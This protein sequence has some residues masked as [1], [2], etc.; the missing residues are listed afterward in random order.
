M[1]KLFL[2]AIAT[3]LFAIS[4]FLLQISCKKDVTAQTNGFT[5][6]PATTSTLG[7]VIVDGTTIKVDAAGKISVVPPSSSNEGAI[8]L[9]NKRTSDDAPDELWRANLDGSG[10]QKINVA[11]PAGIALNLSDGGAMKL[12]PDNQK[13]IF[14]A[15]NTSTNQ[16]YIYSCNI[17]GTG[18]AKLVDGPL[19]GG[20]ELG[21]VN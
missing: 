13:V 8:I 14:L 20:L 4:I 21:A 9:F 7:G 5:L 10:Q 6:L 15:R 12:S 17:D 18:A 3:T 1:K 11:L 2:S 19:N 16:D